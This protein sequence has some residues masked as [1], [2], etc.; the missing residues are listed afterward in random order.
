M[1][2]IINY[3]EEKTLCE[4]SR[5]T[6]SIARPINIDAISTVHDSPYTFH[7]ISIDCEMPVA[8]SP[9]VACSARQLQ[10]RLLRKRNCDV[11]K[12]KVNKF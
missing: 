12:A 9:L 5:L 10:F 2:N 8:A 6:F 11:N 4:V 1:S 3:F 7:G